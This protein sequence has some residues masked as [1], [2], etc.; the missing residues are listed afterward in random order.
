MARRGPGEGT[1][2]RKG[3]GWKAEIKRLGK[4]KT[5]LSRADAAAWLAETLAIAGSATAEPGKSD[6]LLSDWITAWLKDVRRDRDERT[7]IE[8]E[9]IL[10]NHVVPNIGSVRIAELRPMAVRNLLDELAATYAGTRTLQVTH[11]YLSRCLNAAVRLEL[12]PSNPCRGVS[13][14]KS[15]R[16]DIDPFT[17]EE[18]KKILGHTKDHR[19]GA[20]FALA[21]HL[22]PRPAELFGLE[23]QDIDLDAGTL[24]IQRQATQHCGRVY[25][26]PA[27]AESARTLELPGRVI[28]ALHKR[29]K[30][31]MSEGLAGCDIVFPTTAGTH[32]MGP[33]F[34]KYPWKKK[35]L[36]PLKIKNRGLNQT[37]HTFATHA[38]MAGCPLHVVSKILGHSTPSTTLDCYAHLIDTAQSTV[39]DRVAALFAG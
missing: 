36:E 4:S 24:R 28:D 9:R 27:K 22:G 29:R 12:I 14:P 11:S 38:L 32:Y 13:R 18:V 39:V 25:V 1:I 7:A 16:K 37:R 15:R 5:C 20:L 8:Y 33:N 23:W 19:I 31:A 3:K 26:K 35:I 17:N 10:E 6:L 21:V 30:K 34:A 2:F